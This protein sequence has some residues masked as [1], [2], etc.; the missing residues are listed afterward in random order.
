MERAQS[1]SQCSPAVFA[2]KIGHLRCHSRPIGSLSWALVADWSPWWL[3]GSMSEPHWSSLTSHVHFRKS[4]YLA[5]L[6]E[7]LVVK[8]TVSFDL[9][10]QVTC[11]WSG[12][13]EKIPLSRK[14]CTFPSRSTWFSQSLWS[15]KSLRVALPSVYAYAPTQ[16]CFATFDCL[17]ICLDYQNSC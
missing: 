1:H 16:S 3:F 9:H 5:W 6:L 13:S 12:S 10:I 8:L 4:A 2:R 15:W 11:S 7:L 14:D 17:Q